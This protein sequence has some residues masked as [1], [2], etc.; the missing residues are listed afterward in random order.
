MVLAA[1]L[2]GAGAQALAQPHVVVERARTSTAQ[3][4]A[5]RGTYALSDGRELVIGGSAR[6]PTM[7]LG[8]E[9]SVALVKTGENLFETADGQTRIELQTQRNGQVNALALRS[10]QTQAVALR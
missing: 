5:M 4:E 9:P 6:R 10:G 8:M 2:I 7:Q 3:A 1:A